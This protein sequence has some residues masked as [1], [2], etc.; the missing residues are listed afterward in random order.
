MHLFVEWKFGK[1]NVDPKNKSFA[2]SQHD[3]YIVYENTHA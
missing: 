1:I 3:I 2:F